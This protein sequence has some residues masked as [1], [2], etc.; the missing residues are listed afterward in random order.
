[1]HLPSRSQKMTHE[2]AAIYG[3]CSL[4]RI[5]K[6]AFFLDALSQWG[7]NHI[8]VCLSLQWGGCGQSSFITTGLWREEVLGFRKNY[9]WG[10]VPCRILFECYKSLYLYVLA[11]KDSFWMWWLLGSGV[12]RGT[13]QS[14]LERYIISSKSSGHQYSS[15]QLSDH[16]EVSSPSWPWRQHEWRYLHVKSRILC[17]D[18]L[19]DITFSLT[20]NFILFSGLSWYK[21]V[22]FQLASEIIWTR[23][24]INLHWCIW[25]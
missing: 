11:K 21:C 1:M 20:F 15:D 9:L 17:R 6:C 2:T 23:P 19:T 14:G 4:H 5:C 10:T 25:H 8:I 7:R 13:L 12:L 22:G 3:L 24:A 16:R 18:W